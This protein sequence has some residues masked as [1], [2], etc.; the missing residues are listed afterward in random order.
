MRS[1]RSASRGITSPGMASD[2]RSARPT[3]ELIPRGPDVPRD[4]LHRLAG[5]GGELVGA[6]VDGAVCTWLAKTNGQLVLMMWPR[7]FRARFEPLE[8]LDDQGHVVAKGGEFVTV[9][10]GYLPQ[11]EPR[12]LGHERVFAAWTVSGEQPTTP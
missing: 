11:G 10:G 4:A 3:Y 5:N 9:V 1:R 2:A 12:S 8:L 7:T 6:I